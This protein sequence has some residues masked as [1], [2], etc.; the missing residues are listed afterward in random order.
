[1]NEVALVLGMAIVTFIVRYPV[2]VLVSKMPMPQPIADALRYV[3]PA[4]LAAIVVPAVLMP[5][6][7]IDISPGNAYL[8]A[9]IVCIIVAWRTNNLVLTII[10][11]MG[12]MLGWRALTGGL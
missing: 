1:M 3:P 6:G 9:A 11:G 4:V 10:L 12:T 5:K 8:I 7:T 2:M